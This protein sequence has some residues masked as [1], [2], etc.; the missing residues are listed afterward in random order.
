MNWTKTS[1]G[2]WAIE[3]SDLR[4]LPFTGGGSPAA[5]GCPQC[6]KAIEGRHCIGVDMDP[7]GEDTVGW[8]HRHDC[9][10]LLLIIND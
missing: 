5:P 10:A 8:R 1:D 3:A 4:S 2:W 6:G 7:S 9:G